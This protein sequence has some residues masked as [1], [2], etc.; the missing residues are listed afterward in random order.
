M[1]LRTINPT[2]GQHIQCLAKKG[3]LMYD[4]THMGE[5]DSYLLSPCCEHGYRAVY[6]PRP[7]LDF[8]RNKENL[9]ENTLAERRILQRSLAAASTEQ[10]R[11]IIEQQLLDQQQR[12][13]SKSDYNWSNAGGGDQP[14]FFTERQVNGL[15]G[16]WILVAGANIDDSGFPVDAAAKWWTTSQGDASTLEEEL[17]LT[18]QEG[19]ANQTGASFV[20]DYYGRGNPNQVATTFRRWTKGIRGSSKGALDISPSGNVLGEE[21]ALPNPYIGNESKRPYRGF[22]PNTIFWVLYGERAFEGIVRC[23]DAEGETSAIHR[24]HGSGANWSGS[25]LFDPEVLGLI[26]PTQTASG[27]YRPKI[28]F[29]GGD[30]IGTSGTSVVDADGNITG[31]TIDDPGATV[32]T[33]TNDNAIEPPNVT[34]DMPL[35]YKEFDAKAVVST[36]P[37]EIKSVLG[38]TLFIDKASMLAE[39]CDGYNDPI[40]QTFMISPDAHP[41]GVFI[42]RLDL[43]FQSKPNYGTSIPAYVEIRPTV[44]GHPHAE[45][46][47][48]YKLLNVGDVNVASGREQ[49][50]TSLNPWDDPIEQFSGSTRT[51]FYPSFD[52][53]SSF[54]NVTFDVPVYLA[55]GEYAIVVRS[56]DSAYRCWISDINERVVNSNDSLA[57]YGSTAYPDIQTTSNIQQY[58]GVFFRSSNGRTWEPNQNQDLMFRL[59]KCNFGGTMTSS[60]TGTFSLGGS[61]IAT[62]FDYDRLDL[63]TNSI[64]NPNPNATEIS[65]TLKTKE[66]GG[67]LSALSGVSGNL[68]RQRADAKIRDLPATMNYGSGSQPSTS[69]IQLDYTLSTKNPDVSPVVDTRNI[70]AV[71]YRN[72]IS[73]GGITAASIKILNGGSGYTAAT[74]TFTISGGGSTADATV[75]VKST[76]G[77]GEIAEIEVTSAGSGFHKFEDPNNTINPDR[78]TITQGGGGSGTGAELEFLSE[79][80]I[81]GGNSN[82]R[83]ITKNIDLAPGMEARAIKVF[84]S[85][86]EPSG[87]NLYV[88]YKVRSREDGE[89]IQFKKWRLMKR[90][91]PDQ[92]FF[93]SS[94]SPIAG[95][96][97]D[98]VTEYEF[99]TDPVISYTDSD[100]NDHDTFGSF[101]IKI[102]GHATNKAKP[103]VVNNMRAVAVF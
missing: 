55:P 99:D 22:D 14:G 18:D 85:A 70:F 59:H 57:D 51:D 12:G 23:E 21:S 91:G 100:G 72:D 96:L 73:S 76:L 24:T 45:K 86:K 52:N 82:M 90:T 19:Y 97:G 89:D 26:S 40:A 4:V 7:K 29:Y 8:L 80:N 2:L 25:T 49:D 31:V 74:E 103:P 93:S 32:V 15:S 68:I 65:G 94:V 44:N 63:Q 43:C 10:E 5:P 60:E 78:V 33:H 16:S 9:D 77:G 56:N 42:P 64:F 62:A 95:S 30:I 13:A 35:H 6:S 54:T 84:L 79:E 81:D 37:Q 102:V 36:D 38:E 75:R 53:T 39:V 87:S 41:D 83:Y 71:P 11:S 47:I 67:S 46:V 101:S 58:G 50:D 98:S 69:D 48:A 88:Y 61:K 34:V 92:D 28:I 66:S 1:S 27:G 20:R 17:L 3:W